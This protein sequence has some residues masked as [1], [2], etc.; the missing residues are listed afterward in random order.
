MLTGHSGAGAPIIRGQFGREH[1]P[2]SFLALRVLDPFKRQGPAWD[3]LPDTSLWEPSESEVSRFDAALTTKIPPGHEYIDLVDEIWNRGFEVFLVG[4]T[5][6]DVLAGESANDVDLVT[7]MPLAL[8]L[9]V[10]RP[11]F[12][13][14]A[15]RVH[16]NTGFCRLGGTPASG[17]PFI[18]L[19]MV[20][21]DNLGTPNAQFGASLQT[22]VVHRDFACNALYYDPKNKLIVDPTG[23]G[24]ADVERRKLTLVSERTRIL[25]IDAAKIAIR[26]FKFVSRGYE[27]HDSTL[28]TVRNDY[29]VELASMPRSQLVGYTRTQILSKHDAAS[30]PSKLNDFRQVMHELGHAGEWDRYF[31]PVLDDIARG[32]P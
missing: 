15:L 24:L 6:R 7:S 18:D 16:P 31:A 9:D 8:A 11:M 2:S 5:V 13:N 10:L 17:D 32:R 29:I 26:F 3:H 20:C 23:T 28:A 27:P 12:R 22:D 1:R 4:G 25:N 14:D 19:K 30:W 21:L